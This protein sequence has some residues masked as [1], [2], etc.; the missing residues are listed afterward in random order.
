MNFTP[1]YQPKCYDMVFFQASF[2][3]YRYNNART[4]QLVLV[5]ND[6]GGATSQSDSLLAHTFYTA[7]ALSSNR[8]Q[9]V[10]YFSVLSLTASLFVEIHIIYLL[11]HF[12]SLNR[13]SNNQSFYF[14]YYVDFTVTAL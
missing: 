9:A 1:V 11:Q 7:R 10:N 5:S 14:H 12:T 2:P 8:I 3:N 13:C 6:L 4:L